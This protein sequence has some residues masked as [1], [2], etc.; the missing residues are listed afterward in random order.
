MDL[1]K[2]GKFIVKLRREKNMTKEQSVRLTFSGGR[3]CCV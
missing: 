3:I 1:I 2:I